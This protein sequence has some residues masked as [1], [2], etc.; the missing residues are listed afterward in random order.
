MAQITHKKDDCIGC[1][2]CTAICPTNWEMKGDGKATP[3][4]IEISDNE[5]ECN[6]NAA[7]A[8]PVQCIKIE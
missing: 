5:I 8:C 3:K 2:A 7:E 4:K 6:K 1:G